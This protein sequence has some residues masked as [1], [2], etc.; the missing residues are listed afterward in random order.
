MNHLKTLTAL[1]YLSG[2]QNGYATDQQADNFAHDY[3]RKKAQAE[4]ISSF[5]LVDKQYNRLRE[6]IKKS[7][8]PDDA[9][10]KNLSIKLLEQE[11][12]TWMRYK[13]SKCNFETNIYIYPT[14]SKLYIQEYNA[15][16]LRF[17]NERARYFEDLIN[18]L[19]KK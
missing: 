1:L 13:E 9:T 16:S 6:A 4:A 5:K 3:A 19:S 11:H 7:S 10:H 2:I 17:N 12:K 18:E 14:D 15:C 8:Y